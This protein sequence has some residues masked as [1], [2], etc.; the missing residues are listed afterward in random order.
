MRFHVRALTFLCLVAACS[1][2]LSSS[3]IGEEMP[4]KQSPALAAL[5]RASMCSGW[6]RLV[7]VRTSGTRDADGVHGTFRRVLD[8]A[9]GAWSNRFTNIAF[10]EGDG[11]DGAVPWVLDHSGASHAL[12]AR[13]ALAL[14]RTDAWIGR[15]G[16]CSVRDRIAAADA[17]VRS[18]GNRAFDVVVVTPRDGAPEALWIDRS[19][20]LLDRTIAQLNESRRIEHF[21]DW[22]LYR[23]TVMPFED[24]VEYPE[25]QDL[26]R[27]KIAHIASIAAVSRWAF[28]APP[29]PP[30]VSI[31]GGGNATHVP[32]TLEGRVLV[33]VMLNGHGPFPF[34]VDTGA[35]F[36]LT[37]ATARR[38]G[39]TVRGQANSLGQGETIRL[40]GFAR[41]ASMRI[42]TA[43][44]TNQV[45]KILPYGFRRTE[46]GPR[47]P[48][49]GWLGVEFFERFAVTFDPAHH[50]LTLRRLDRPRPVPPG[51]RV[52][53]AFDEDAPLV[54]CAVDG[55]PGTC[56]IDTG[57]TGETIVEGHWAARSGLARRLASGLDAYG[58]GGRVDRA[59]IAIGP[60][61]GL[62]DVVEWLPPA[63]RGSEATTVEA[64][65]LSED[66]LSRFVMTVDERTS[67]VW[68]QPLPHPS[69]RPF[70]R[71]GFL[72]HAERDGS[73]TVWRVLP[74]SPAADAGLHVRDRI[75]AVDGIP[76]GHFSHVD[77]TT[78]DEGP[79]GTRRTYT[80]VCG[81]SAPHTIT[82][83][84]RELLRS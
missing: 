42:G 50:L 1:F 28:S 78:L 33:N 52:P 82:L 49:A 58:D 40:A 19:S 56:M 16:W 84:L 55:L 6:R 14:A 76:T 20:H 29:L 48:I 31:A 75:V 13:G 24:D 67:A 17:G 8:V 11:F 59:T 35:H 60:F 3:S 23:D 53:I 7:A 44:M 69:P 10:A 45:A 54:G 39:L 66:V 71:A 63:K 46:R 51:T 4:P 47:A 9:T 62:P 22:R 77:L 73:F 36:I 25:D 72:T 2:S 68:L 30:D 18:E 34:A 15:R 74:G 79:V 64:A 38:F 65:I 57:N 70:D 12:D 81:S 41:V 32:Y 21:A 80:I 37:A 5:R 61:A 27:M 83:R 43:T 26:E